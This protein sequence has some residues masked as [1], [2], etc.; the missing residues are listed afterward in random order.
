VN[1]YLRDMVLQTNYALTTSGVTSADMTPD[2]RFVVF[3]INIS[4]Y[5]D[6]YVFD[7]YSAARIFTNSSGSS[8]VSSISIS[9]NG[10]RFAYMGGPTTTK[11]VDLVAKTNWSI[12]TGTLKSRAK[13][14]FSADGRFLAHAKNAG[15]A[16]GTQLIAVYDVDAGTNV[17]V[18]RAY[19]TGGTPNGSSYSP[20]ISADG[21]FVAYVS[22]A[23]NLVPGDLNDVPDVFMY[24]RVAD[25]TMML[26]VR[27]S[28]S[29]PANQRSWSPVFSGDG[30]TL[31]FASWASDLVG[32][33]FNQLSD[34]F[35][36]RLP[37]PAIADSDGDGMDDS[38]E[39]AH[40]ATLTRD[41]TG[42]FD[43]DGATDLFEFQSGTDP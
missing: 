33:D 36:Y 24:D 25:A 31:V 8:S 14:K 7:S 11:V 18:T 5:Y 3:P 15:D 26:S 4:G 29:A 19:D 40:W 28:N 16:L 42:D 39:L 21:R 6:L 12:T 13:P 34:L 27:Q 38:W 43:G 9:P 37:P 23:T 1:L 20:D 22:D 17:V 41:G 10:W 35:A 32:S 2:G 30:R